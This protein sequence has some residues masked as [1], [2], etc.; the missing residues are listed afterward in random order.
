ML[1][2]AI[3]K[4]QWKCVG[5]GWNIIQWHYLLSKYRKHQ[6]VDTNYGTRQ[7]LASYGKQE[8]NI[9]HDLA[10]EVLPGDSLLRPASLLVGD[11]SNRFQFASIAALRTPLRRVFI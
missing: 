9:G 5:F 7:T 4:V 1:L 6:R 8:C 2:T 10:P 3:S 11:C